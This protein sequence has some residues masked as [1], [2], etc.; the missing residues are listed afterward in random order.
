MTL[1]YRK[2]I[3]GL[4]ALAVVPVVLFHAFPALL[5]GGF[6]GVDIFFVISGFLISSI[7]I[8]STADGT[9]TYKD[10]YIRRINRIFPTL[11]LSSLIRTIHY[12]MVKNALSLRMGCQC[13]GIMGITQFMAL[14]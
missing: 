5:P 2:D 10:F 12:V 11:A 3:D 14:N 1:H 13:L 6:V 7:I 8:K 4:R 9:F